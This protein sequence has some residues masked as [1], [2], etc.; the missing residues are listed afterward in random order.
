M[1]KISDA[2]TA[3]LRRGSVSV[4]GCGCDQPKTVG[5]TFVGVIRIRQR[6]CLIMAVL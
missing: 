4:R 1:K 2:A 3:A 5:P 6:R